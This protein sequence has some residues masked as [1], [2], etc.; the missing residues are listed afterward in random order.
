M[1]LSGDKT[2]FSTGMLQ[3][4][5]EYEKST[6]HI[7]TKD[8]LSDTSNKSKHSDTHLSP[9]GFFWRVCNQ[10]FS[11]CGFLGMGVQSS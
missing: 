11:V 9:R 10:W 1:D 7:N 5:K 6:A 2:L 8:M 4:I 3:I